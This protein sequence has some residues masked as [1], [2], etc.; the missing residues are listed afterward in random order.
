VAAVA[1][2]ERTDH[3]FETRGQRSNRPTLEDRL[4]ATWDELTVTGTAEC[5]V[6]G[7]EL[8]AAGGCEGCGSELS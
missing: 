2:S 4:L 3:L 6:C 1:V 5:P 7:S 8:H